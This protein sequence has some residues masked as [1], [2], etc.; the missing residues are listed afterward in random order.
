M[1]HFGP[2]SLQ[3]QPF[4]EPLICE[5]GRSRSIA[6]PRK[7]AGPISRHP[8]QGSTVS[9]PAFYFKETGLN[10]AFLE[11]VARGRPVGRG[12]PRFRGAHSPAVP[13]KELSFSL[14]DLNSKTT[15]L[16]RAT[17]EPVARSRPAGR[18]FPPIPRIPFFCRFP[19]KSY[20]FHRPHF[21]SKKTG[22]N[23]AFLELVA[24]GR[25]AG[26]G[27]PPILRGHFSAVSP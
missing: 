9:P 21:T 7:S 18:G 5:L 10:R 20:R 8:P 14:P 15:V 12:F 6:P 16:N 17:P 22:L 27:F 25:P 2:L 11:L 1:S 19:L 24:R 4:I 3:G 26:R 23:R 13:H